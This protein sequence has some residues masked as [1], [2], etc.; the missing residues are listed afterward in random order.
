MTQDVQGSVKPRYAG[1]RMQRVEDGRLL[2]GHGSFVD[3]ISRPGMFK[4][5]GIGEVTGAALASA[6]LMAISNA[7]GVDVKEYPATPAVVL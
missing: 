4:A 1:T 5:L 6:A 3:D 2:T 7:I